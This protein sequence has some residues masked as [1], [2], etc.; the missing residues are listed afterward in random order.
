M[1]NEFLFVYGTLRKFNNN[2]MHKLLNCNSDYI[3]EAY[4]KGKLYR[5]DDYPALIPS[6]DPRDI[7]IGEVYRL[8]N[9]D[10]IKEI[11]RYEEYGE[12]FPTPNEFIRKKDFV[13]MKDKR[14]RECFIYF[15]NR[16]VDGLFQIKSGDFLAG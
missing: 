4:Y 12:E 13:T 10:V 5:V 7:V 16:K 8:K 14:K 1:K 15:Y 3:G 9:I 2:D 6:K 11:D